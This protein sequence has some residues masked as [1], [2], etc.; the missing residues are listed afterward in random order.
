[1]RNALRRKPE[2]ILVGE[3]RDRETMSAVIEAALTGHPVYT[4]L[5]SNGVAEAVRRLVGT[6]P[7]EERHSRTLDIVETMR[8]VLWQKLVPTTDGRRTALKE[9]L[10][11]DDKIRDHLLS[12]PTEEVTHQTRKYLRQYGRTMDQ[13]AKMKYDKGVIDRH[14]Y[15]LTITASSNIDED[16]ETTT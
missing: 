15:E 2:L 14:T 6:F 1:V 11:F 9:Y 13:D 3:A 12:I 4:T 8:V 16:I 10:V 5:H 7:P